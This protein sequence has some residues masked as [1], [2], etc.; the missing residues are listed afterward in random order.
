MNSAR[1]P[2]T[3]TSQFIQADDDDED[4]DEDDIP[5]F[6]HPVLASPVGDKGKARAREPEVLAP[7]TSG[8]GG[9]PALSGNIGSSADGAARPARQT[10]G[11]LQVETRYSGIDTLD[12][13]VTTTIARD[14]LSIYAK[15]VQVLY[16]RKS[17][18]REVLRQVDR[19]HSAIINI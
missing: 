2:L 7:P 1:T 16:P 19:R 14:L 15:L 11:G 3:A 13:P 12:E 10:V 4:L 5:G 8:R 6:T 17:S 18:G 9:S